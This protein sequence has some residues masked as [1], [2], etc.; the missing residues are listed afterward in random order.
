MTKTLE[1]MMKVLGLATV[2]VLGACEASVAG[3][4]AA[5]GD[6]AAVD[7]GSTGKDTTTTTADTGPASVSYSHVAIDGSPYKE[8]DCKATTSPGPDLDA[9]GLY[10]A[11]KLI[12]VAKVGSAVFK[13]GLTPACAAEN[14][15]AEVNDIEGP[16]NAD[17]DKGYFGVSN[18]TVE[19]EFGAC[20]VST[21]VI[22]DCDGSGASVPILVGDEIDVYEVDKSYKPD[23][24]GPQKGRAS[25]AC[26]C[27]SEDYELFVGSAGKVDKSLGKFTGSKPQIAVK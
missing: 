21:N 8:V 27:L 7:G 11:G 4:A 20:T 15:H 5:A 18:G 3:D 12:G 24:S 10:R 23:G 6:T 26:K 16:L 1:K 2:L 19:F 14:K 13:K 22:T 17:T 25:A 9:I